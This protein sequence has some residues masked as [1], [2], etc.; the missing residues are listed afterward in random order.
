MEVI[1][2]SHSSKFN[3]HREH[4]NHKFNKPL[5]LVDLMGK[6]VP[7]DKTSLGQTICKGLLST[8]HSNHF[9]S[10]PSNQL[11]LFDPNFHRVLLEN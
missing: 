9:C 8:I 11:S 2:N 7:L 5:I 6:L 4:S 1:I 3:I 10:S